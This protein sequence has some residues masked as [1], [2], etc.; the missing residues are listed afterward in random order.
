MGMTMPK[1]TRSM[2][3]V[4]KRTKRGERGRAI[5][6]ERDKG[7]VTSD[8]EETPKATSR[9]PQLVT[10]HMS[11][12]T[13]SSPVPAI[14]ARDLAFGLAIGRP[15]LQVGALIVRDFALGHADLGFQTAVFPV[16]LQD[17]QGATGD[18]G[19]AVK[20]VDLLFVK[21]ETADAFRGRNILAGLRVGLDVGVVKKGL[22]FLNADEGI[23]DV[24]LAGADRFDLAPFQLDAGFVALED[25]KIAER[26]AIEDRFGG[27]AGTVAQAAPLC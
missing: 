7:R 15:F 8:K 1:P 13:S 23:A 25:V 22:A 24:R 2:K 3:T 16:Q 9:I 14:E 26:L 11:L 10:Y 5:F 6:E 19:E 27:H 17:H 21:K 4:R 12:V 20:F 18:R